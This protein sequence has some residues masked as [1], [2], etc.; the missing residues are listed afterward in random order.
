MYAKQQKTYIYVYTYIYIYICK[1]EPPGALWVASPMGWV[2]KHFR[3]FGSLFGDKMALGSS[4]G[5]GSQQA[6]ASTVIKS[7]WP[8]TLVDV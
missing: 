5:D 2:Q 8:W 6:G 1:G 4:W 7:F 3:V